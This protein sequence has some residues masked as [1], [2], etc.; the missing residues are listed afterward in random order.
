MSEP[1]RRR[2]LIVDDE[3]LY[4]RTTAALLRKAGYECET[5]PDGA[6]ALEALSSQP[7]DLV[8][9]D[10][11]MPG[12]R[13]LELLHAQRRSWPDI[14]LIVVTG[15]PS[16][17]TAIESLR[18]GLADY[19]LKPVRFQDL[20]NSIERALAH[21]HPGATSP[22]Q[23]PSPPHDA[24]FPELIGSSPAMQ[25]VRGILV[26]IARADANVLITGE[27]GV[28]KEVVARGIHANS[29]RASHPFQVIDCTSIPESL[30][31]SVVF[32]HARGAF[33][34]AVRDQEGLLSQSDKGT[35]F[36][37][38]IGELPLPLQSKLLRVIQEQEF[39]P[40]GRTSPVRFDARFLSA[41]NRNLDVEV[42]AGRFRRDLFY[43]LAVIHLELPPLRARE[44]DARL[45]AE[46][47]LRELQPRG[48]RV[49]AFS[50]DAAN[51]LA[52]YS[53]PG[54]IRELRNAVER[55]LALASSDVITPTD[56]P[57]AI[58]AATANSAPDAG[59]AS[60]GKASPASTPDARAAPTP[61][62]AS[63]AST[64]DP[65][66]AA[67]PEASP[68]DGTESRRETLLSADRDYLIAILKSNRGNVTGAARQAG[69]SRQGL[70]KRLKKAGVDPRDYR[71][72]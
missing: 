52:S 18:L 10:L 47:F 56:L 21:S 58:A 55:G 37:D 4:L 63:A 27:S 65:G 7:F 54:N 49:A 20:H 31:E 11:N 1:A 40:L 44:G 2:I 41:T 6:A 33:T 59:A 51:L 50:P 19:L 72:N 9:S 66:A 14:P 32:G 16:L 64:P 45:L 12:N 23:S 24:A 29:Q 42:N 60:S 36:F 34:G 3:P 48:M 69:M 67:A 35:V 46:H 39:T 13:D 57:P 30:F 8:L 43:R 22:T 62:D 61:D 15:A 26:R 68:A 25:E 28:G 38:E 70:H 17:P 71:K 5:A 53:W